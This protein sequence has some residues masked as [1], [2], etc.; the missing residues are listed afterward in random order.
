MNASDADLKPRNN[1]MK[2]QA[3]VP[4]SKREIVA[5]HFATAL[6]QS[7]DSQPDRPDRTNRS[8]MLDAFRFAEAFLDER[9]RNFEEHPA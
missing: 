8:V 9:N 7:R 3:R 4:F 6:I 2:I 5:L 1:V